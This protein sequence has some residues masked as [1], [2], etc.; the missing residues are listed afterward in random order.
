MPRIQALRQ[1][2]A[3]EHDKTRRGQVT[4]GIGS[5]VNPL[6][7]ASPLH[8][9]AVRKAQGDALCDFYVARRAAAER[10]AEAAYRSAET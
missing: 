6:W 1:T 10:E 3:G 5:Q 2:I 4:A 8:R 9:N 7:R